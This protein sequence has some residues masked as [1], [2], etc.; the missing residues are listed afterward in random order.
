VTGAR[1]VVRIDGAAQ[2]FATAVYAG[3]G[4][5]VAIERPDQGARSYLA[6]GGGIDV[7]PVLG[8]RS[9]DTLAG[10][11]PP[12]VVVGARLPIG[13]TTGDP[14]PHETPR[15]RRSGPVRVWPGPR[16][17]WFADG[18][19]VLLCAGPFT[20]S[21]DSNRIGVR[22]RGTPIVR[23]RHDEL[24]SEGIVLGSIQVPPDG[25]PVVLLHDHP[26]TGGYPVLAVVDARDLGT[27]AQ[28]A[29]GD[30]VRLARAR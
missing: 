2:P 12:V 25:Q 23:V 17:D 6:V 11:G 1:S 22:L 8:S 21:A 24:R 27:L 4:A 30:E 26:V 7:E 10:V 14:Q 20:V 29:P 18:E 19:L 13:S 28:A 9:T 16:A 3:P 15:P 5:T